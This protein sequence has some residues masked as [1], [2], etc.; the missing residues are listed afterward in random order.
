MKAKY[1]Q[2]FEGQQW[3]DL[4]HNDDLAIKAAAY[5]LKMLDDDA[6]SKATAA[7]RADQFLGS[8]YNAG[9]TVE[10]SRDVAGGNHPFQSNEVEHGQ[11]TVSV[12]ELANTILCGSG[13]YQ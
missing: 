2:Q 3:S 13:A 4:A 12:V 8:G 7:V 5:N 11:S 9:G 10:R 6:A 1:P